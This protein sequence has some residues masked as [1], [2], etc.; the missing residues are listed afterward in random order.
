VQQLSVGRE[1]DVLGLHGGVNRDPFKV[2]AA[3]CAALVRHPQA[4]GQ[5]QFHFVAKALSP[6]AQVRTLMRE[7]MLEELFP[8]EVLEIGGIDPAFAHSFVG[9]LVNM[10]EQQ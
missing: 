3:Q 2:L 4:L 5:K 1:A 8:G 7:L 6:M 9:Q 10:L